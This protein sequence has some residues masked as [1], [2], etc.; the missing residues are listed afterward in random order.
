[1][2]ACLR[3]RRLSALPGLTVGGLDPYD[4]RALLVWTHP[5]PM[6]ERV[7]GRLVAESRGNPLALLE[8][9]RG[10]VVEEQA[11]GFWLSR[12]RGIPSVEEDF[13]RRV[14]ALPGATRALLLVVAAEPLGDPVPLWRAAQ[15]SVWIATDRLTVEDTDRFPLGR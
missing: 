11:G 12:W 15:V 4:A 8:R 1:M 2:S 10:R 13:R 3:C 6:D 5:G 7:R 14:E 9:A